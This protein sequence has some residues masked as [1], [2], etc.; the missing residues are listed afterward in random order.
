ML[1]SSAVIENIMINKNGEI[2][3][4]DFGLS[5][6]FDRQHLLKTYCGSLYFAAP[7]LLSA[8]PYIGPE[9]DVWSFGVVLYVLV[10]GKVPFDDQSVS[11]LHE[12]IKKGHVEYPDKL[13]RECVSLLSRMLVVDPTKRASLHEVMA[14][15][16]MVKGFECPPS[17]YLPHRT[18]LELPLDPDVLQ[19]MVEYELV[20]SE[21]QASNELTYLLTSSQY[22]L[23][24][25][26]WHA[27]YSQPE[28]Y[29]ESI[30]DPTLGFHP[31]I[32]IYYLVDEMLKRK[33]I[34]EESNKAR[35]SQKQ[36]QQQQQQTQQPFT[37]TPQM[38]QASNFNN[39][40]ASHQRTFSTPNPDPR[41]LQQQQEQQ[42]APVLT[43]PQAAYTSSHQQS[44]TIPA[45]TIT[46]NQV[47]N[48]STP[49]PQQQIPSE[50]YNSPLFRKLKLQA[51][52]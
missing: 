21:Q 23:A 34:K 40:P 29:D 8:H 43:F 49:P 22:Q 9:V 12:K 20:S 17:N 31:L 52:L 38:A 27:R 11:A 41:Y 32:S 28:L 48:E 13:S 45:T 46:K 15:P 4:I 30:Q 42:Q 25:K 50:A 37:T 2:K 10:C 3:I 33:R 47:R 51:V 1:V 36:S 16:W 7:E 5:N 44:D 14:H 18:P 39:V 19:I 24:T 35:V 26:N 6:M